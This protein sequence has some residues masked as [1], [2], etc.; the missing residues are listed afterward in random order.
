MAQKQKELGQKILNYNNAKKDPSGSAKQMFNSYPDVVM[1]LETSS[2]VE[3]SSLDQEMKQLPDRSL[4]VSGNGDTIRQKRVELH[5][6]TPETRLGRCTTAEVLNS[7]TLYSIDQATLL[8]EPGVCSIQ[9]AQSQE[10]D[11]VSLAPQGNKHT[12]AT[13][14]TSILN[15]SGSDNAGVAIS[16]PT[17]EDQ[18]VCCS[19]SLQQHSNISE[20]STLESTHNYCAT[21]QK[22]IFLTNRTALDD[23]L[24]LTG[25]FSHALSLIRFSQNPS[26]SSDNQDSE[27]QL[28]FKTNRRK[29]KQLLDLLELGKIKPGD[30]VLEF[31]LQVN[32]PSTK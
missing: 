31:T 28:K 10:I 18:H 16:Q 29:R 12:P 5:N 19:E 13:P 23:N 22:D 7:K 26:Q 15:F 4:N 3:N 17:T 24:E 1:D 6:M 27:K 20:E 30:D 8:S 14:R 32:Y 2:V 11:Y 21:Y 25:M 9:T